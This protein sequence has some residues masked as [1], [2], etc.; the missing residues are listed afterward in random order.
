MARETAISH[1]LAAFGNP[2]ISIVDKDMGFIGKIFQDFFSPRNIVLQTVIPGHL[3]SL[4][5]EERRRG[6]FR[7]IVDHIVGNRK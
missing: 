1:L 4:G 5:A 7:D 2:D 6:Q 3:Q